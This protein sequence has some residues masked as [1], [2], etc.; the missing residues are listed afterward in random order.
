VTTYS[1]MNNFHIE[2][3]EPGSGFENKG[4]IILQNKEYELI[5]VAEI[6]E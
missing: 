1:C 6:D 5:R 2:Q 4:V 3:I